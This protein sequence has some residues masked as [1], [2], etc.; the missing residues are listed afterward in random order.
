MTNRHDIDGFR[1][2]PI[3]YNVRQARS[4]K[5]TRSHDTTG[6]EVWVLTEPLN[7]GQDVLANSASR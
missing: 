2:D 1:G 5:L 3:G 7:D 4:H 6:S